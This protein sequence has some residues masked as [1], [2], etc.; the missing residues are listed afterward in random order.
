M[1]VDVDVDVDDGG[2]MLGDGL[3]QRELLMWDHRRTVF[4]LAIRCPGSTSSSWQLLYQLLFLLLLTASYPGYVHPC[5]SIALLE[6]NGFHVRLESCTRSRDLDLDRD[7][8]R[9][10]HLRWLSICR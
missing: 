9:D 7:R 6:I 5:G 2:W 8:D 4:P 10:H 1:D 3:A